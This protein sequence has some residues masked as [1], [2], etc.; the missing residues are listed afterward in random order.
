MGRAYSVAGV[1]ASGTAD[2]TILGVTA[3]A[4]VR[5]CIFDLV[6]GNKQTPADQAVQVMLQRYT[7]AG[8]AT[9]VTPEPVDPGDPASAATAGQTHSAEPTYTA[10]K[11]VLQF[12]MNQRGTFRW[13]ATPGYEFKAPATAANGFGL[14]NKAST[15]AMTLD[16]TCVFFE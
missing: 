16:G 4:A 13:V 7:A 2:K 8:T 9:A 15:A 1:S 14:L 10:G 12:G 6:V 3:T 5:P 11:I